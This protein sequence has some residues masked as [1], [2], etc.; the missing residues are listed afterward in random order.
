MIE[1]PDIPRLD[2]RIMCRLAT[3]PHLEKLHA[4]TPRLR[5]VCTVLFDLK[6]APL[7]SIYTTR[8]GKLFRDCGARCERRPSNSLFRYVRHDADTD[9][10]PSEAEYSTAFRPYFS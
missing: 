4:S 9:M 1:T 7:Q 5:N 10:V 8:S 6:P 3:V 2:V